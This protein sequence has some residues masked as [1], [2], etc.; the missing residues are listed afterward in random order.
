MK[1]NSSNPTAGLLYYELKKLC[2]VGAAIVFVVLMAAKLLTAYFYAPEQYDFSTELYREYVDILRGELTEDKQQY[3]HDE[4]KRLND[5][6]KMKAVMQ[7]G[8]NRGVITLEEFREYN[9]EYL[10][11]E[12]QL[13]AFNAVYEKYEYFLTLEDK[14][15]IFFYDLDTAEYL[16]DYGADV[17]FI[18]FIIIFGLRLWDYDRL[19][20]IS[21]M[22][23]ATPLSG[24][25][26]D[27]LRFAATAA[28]AVAGSVISFVPDIVSFLIR[29]GSGSLFMPLC[30]IAD[31]GGCPYN[32]NVLG[33]M[34]MML[35]LR[36]IWSVSVCFML[37]FV[38]KLIK[39]IYA[40][41]ALSAAVIFLPT[42]TCGMLP[43]A[44][45]TVLAGAQ[46]TGY[47]VVDGTVLL[48]VCAA[49]I[50]SVVFWLLCRRLK[51]SRE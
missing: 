12:K 3:L 7:D 41:I 19:C 10:R 27:N 33:Y 25:K 6:L 28:V 24:P 5:V 13:P 17:L 21:L 9:T 37:G 11:A 51:K 4:Q 2:G 15:P 47:A 1:R 23:A 49:V 38:Y 40:C 8:Y 48:S 18:L 44:A 26:R 46:L 39:N 20:G 43:Q 45:R 32:V 22:S 42:L 36:I 50:T 30:S 29:C 16:G 14:T 35:G 34:L 31:F